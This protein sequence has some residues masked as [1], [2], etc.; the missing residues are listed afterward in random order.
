MTDGLLAIISQKAKDMGGFEKKKKKR[1]KNYIGDLE[2]KSKLRSQLG[3]Q[4]PAGMEVM[5]AEF[6]I[7]KWVMK[8]FQ[9]SSFDFRKKAC[10][11]ALTPRSISGSCGLKLLN[12]PR[13]FHDFGTQEIGD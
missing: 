6:F 4:L 12:G 2:P 1:K 13:G 7:S 3:V 9:I 5:Q 11:A 10:R 8:M